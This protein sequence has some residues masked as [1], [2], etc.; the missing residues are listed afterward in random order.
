[1]A[2]D[3]NERTVP[4]VTG[5]PWSPQRL[6]DIALAPVYAGKRQHVVGAKS[7]HARR[8]VEVHTYEGSW[9]GIVTVEQFNAVH[10]LLTDPKRRTSRPGRAKHLLSMITTCGVCG[11]V[12]IAR[13]DHGREGTYICRDKSCVRVPMDELDD[14]IEALLLTRL[15]DPDE[16]RHL[17]E[18]DGT[19]EQ[20]QSA[21]DEV[22]E[23]QAHYD[24][25]KSLTKARK[26]SAAAFADMEPDVLGD[27]AR[28]QQR[29]TELETPSQLLPLLGD[30]TQPLKVRWDKA[31]P[32]AKR[33]VVRLLF[34]SIRVNRAASPGHRSPISDR[35]LVEPK[36]PLSMP[37]A[38]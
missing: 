32:V 6:R 29:L 15:A 23:I 35:V 25:M 16:Y 3:L 2:A 10:R 38:E 31:T 19:D 13:F 7:G 27:L 12:L 33:T 26:M 1:M 11:G 28:A 24:E 9:D 8:Q 34:E 20:V 37:G 17:I 30:P 36:R 18:D 5:K 4:T 14:Y 21:R 22:A